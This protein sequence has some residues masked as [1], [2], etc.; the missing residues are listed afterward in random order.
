[1]KQKRIMVG[2]VVFCLFLTLHIGGK[3]EASDA[4]IFV[5]NSD[6]T[7]I[8]TKSIGWCSDK[9]GS[10]LLTWFTGCTANILNTPNTA[11]GICGRLYAVMSHEQKKKIGNQY[12]YTISCNSGDR[13]QTG[14]CSFGD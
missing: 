3:A 4:K 11:D 14:Q 1:M 12:K 9:C 13:Q 7:S 6:G 8:E 2:L 5:K 10:W